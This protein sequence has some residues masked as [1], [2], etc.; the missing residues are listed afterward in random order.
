MVQRCG[1]R[2][3][4]SGSVPSREP[5]CWTWPARG[6]CSGAF[7]LAEAGLLDGR[8]ATTHWRFLPELKRRFPRTDVVDDE[9]FVRDG[10]IWTSAGISAGIDL[11]LAL[12]E[13]DHGHAVAMAVAKNLV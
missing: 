4:A 13:E 9:I 1:E 6:R 12:V 7:V 10:R 8:R 3:D 5:S 11:A 2:P